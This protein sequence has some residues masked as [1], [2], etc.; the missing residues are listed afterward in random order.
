MGIGHISRRRP[1]DDDAGERRGKHD[2]QIQH[3]I[4]APVGPQGEDV[5]GDQDGQQNAGRLHR[6]NDKRHQRHA[7]HGQRPDKSSLRQPDEENRGNGDGVEYGIGDHGKCEPER[8]GFSASNVHTPFGPALKSHAAF[9]ALP[10]SR[11]NGTK[12]G[13]ASCRERV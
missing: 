7:Q 11:N 13:R 10:L 3:M 6:R 9:V 2:F 5:H 12:I 4:D 1:A 8:E